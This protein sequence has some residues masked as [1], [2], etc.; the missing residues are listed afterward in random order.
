MKRAGVL[1]YIY[2]LYILAVSG[3]AVF[4]PAVS[5]PAEKAGS[6]P[7]RAPPETPEAAA[8]IAP[9]KWMVRSLPQLTARVEFSEGDTE[10]T[11]E[12]GVFFYNSIRNPKAVAAVLLVADGELYPLEGFTAA[13]AKSETH[14]L[15]ISAPVSKKFLLAVLKA[16]I[17]YLIAVIDKIEYQFE[18]DREFAA[19]KDAVLKE[20]ETK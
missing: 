16:E 7:E 4:G 11:A 3:C 6:S 14:E 15:R 8:G 17:L 19:Y 2:I 13:S 9:S 20:L 5:G 10:G 12:C 1:L 18:P